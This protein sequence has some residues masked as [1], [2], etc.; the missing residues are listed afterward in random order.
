MV[1]IIY[2]G[3]LGNNLFQYVAAYIFA[4][5]FNLKIS[6]NII[7]NKF[8]LPTLTGVQNI[9]PTINVDDFNFLSLLDSDY[10]KPAQ[11]RFVG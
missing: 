1:S 3:R 2:S 11:Y 9:N 5:K 6:S 8:G 7:E 10:L 4:K